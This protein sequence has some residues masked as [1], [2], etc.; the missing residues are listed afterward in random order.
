MKVML[1]FRDVKA[2]FYMKISLKRGRTLFL[3]L[4]ESNIYSEKLSD[5]PKVTLPVTDLDLDVFLPGNSIF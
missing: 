3:Y 1:C 4:R 5:L 2:H